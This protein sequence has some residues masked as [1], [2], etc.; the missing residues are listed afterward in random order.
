[1]NIVHKIGGYM[2]KSQVTKIIIVVALFALSVLAV[3]QACA[4]EARKLSKRN[5]D[6]SNYA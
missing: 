6:Q 4:T 1:M 2:N 3:N 5:S